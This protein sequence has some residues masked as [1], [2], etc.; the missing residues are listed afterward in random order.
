MS[1][2][3]IVHI[4]FAAKD[5]KTTAKFYGD[6]FGW[7]IQEVPEMNYIMF[8]FGDGTGGGFP[9]VDG[10]VMNP[11]DV[12]VYI[13]TEDIPGTLAKIEGAGG[14]TLL[15]ETEIPGM[16]WY[17]FFEDPGGV[18]AALYKSMSEG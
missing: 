12:V 13:S 5:P 4:E 6:I 1:D 18:R 15:G 2:H 11:G 3:K 14:K 9:E 16:G 10:E 7:D 8:D 17:A